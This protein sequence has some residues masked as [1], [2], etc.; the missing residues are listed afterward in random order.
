MGHSQQDLGLGV[1]VGRLEVPELGW[2]GSLLHPPSKGIKEQG[3]STETRGCAG[4]YDHPSSYKAPGV[5][6]GQ[7]RATDLERFCQ[8]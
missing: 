1:S 2:R 5:Q 6:Q 3:N 4:G 7:G 8:Q